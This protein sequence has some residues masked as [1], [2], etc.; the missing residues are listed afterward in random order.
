MTNAIDKQKILL[1]IPEYL[2]LYQD[3]A[4]PKII[5]AIESG[6]LDLKAAGYDDLPEQVKFI[7][8]WENRLKQNCPICD[9]HCGVIEFPI[10][11]KIRFVVICK[12]TD[13]DYSTKVFA[14]ESQGM[15]A[16]YHN[17]TKVRKRLANTASY[18]E[19][20]KAISESSALLASQIPIDVIITDV[21]NRLKG[22][23]V[24]LQEAVDNQLKNKGD[25]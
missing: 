25:T 23:D 4:Y 16:H 1:L 19:I 12:R 17:V 14:K 9:S 22:D 8:G 2:V 5:E 15:L 6:D 20:E 10:E 21:I 13:C 7:E 11:D 18:D 24:V 3:K